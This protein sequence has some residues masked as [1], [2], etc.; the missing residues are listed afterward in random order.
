M[1]IR[2]TKQY[3]T[4][5]LSGKPIALPPLTLIFNRDPSNDDFAQI[6]VSWINSESDTVWVLTSTKNGI[7]NWS[8]SP[9]S[10]LGVFN[11]VTVNPGN[12]DITAGGLTITAGDLNLAAG[13]TFLGG[14]LTVT[15]TT[16]INGDFDLTSAA[17]IDLISTANIDPAIL[18]HSTG[19]V[20]STIRLTVDNGT[21]FDS[22]DLNSVSGGITLDAGLATN[23]AINIAASA[24][25][26]DMT[27]ALKINIDSAEISNS[28]I[29][30]NASA[31]GID[32]TA[33]GAAGLDIDI[34]NTGGSIN[35]ISGEPTSTAIVLNAS[36]VVGGISILSGDFGTAITAAGQVNID[37]SKIAFDAIVLNASLGGIDITAAGGIGLDIDI[38]NTSGSINIISGEAVVDSI[39]L[40]T[41]NIAGGIEIDSGTGGTNIDSTGQIYIVSSQV[42]FD[43]ILLNASAGGIDIT[44]AGA[45]GLDIDIKNTAG[46]VNIISGEAA[47]DSI[48][49]NT[50]NAAGGIYIESGTNGIAIDSTGPTNIDSSEIS[51][52]AIAFNASAGGI[53]ITAAGAPGLDIDIKN[54]AGSINIISNEPIGTAVVLN[55]SSVA[56]GISISSG[57]LGTTI[58]S[59]GALLLNGAANSNFS[60]SGAGVNLALSS[61]AGAV[62]ITSGQNAIDSIVLETDSGILESVRIT[63]KQGTSATSI[64]CQSLVGG[65]SVSTGLATNSS[66]VLNAL[67]GGIDID[68]VL[69]VNI[70]SSEISNNAIA[71]NA[72]A[73]G[74]DITAA[75]AP[76]L[77]IDI[78][79]TSG[80]INIISGEPIDTAVVL[81]ATSVAGGIRINSGGPGTTIGSTGP[82]NFDTTDP[83]NTAIVV[84]AIAGGID[85]I[86]GGVFSVDIKSQGYFTSE[87]GTATDV[88]GPAATAAVTI[89]TNVCL[90]TLS[91][92]TTAAAA[93]LVLTLTNS[94][95]TAGSGIFVSASTLGA[96]DAQMT[97]TR[98][99]PGVGTCDITLT[100]NGAA[101]VNGD[102]LVSVWVFI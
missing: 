94:L 67:T 90:A 21:S 101:A 91:N 83:S 63:S 30:L 64:L 11:S 59:T 82:I 50:S 100:N 48:L 42:A 49:L 25:G 34:N 62:N 99:L 98:V 87:S 2:K 43:A 80:S 16:A 9:A 77:D 72:S 89:N 97:V 26:I 20:L 24:G 1:G 57:S 39:L 58:G 73:G 22:I 17:L 29:L 54:T 7:A 76:G 93:A 15:G 46:S 36:D 31:G 32:I 53:D 13:N 52:S 33:A 96:N 37:S 3:Y 38:R 4:Y 85:L 68:G 44:A 56:G 81:N 8:T 23:L 19:G 41:S 27:G 6:G 51:N 61:A 65:F 92:F 10:G 55:A 40:N 69:Q 14:N 47:I 86:T 18:L 60:V 28:A 71:F 79:N 102:I 78:N 70:A 45:A 95:I 5:S 84:N 74:I 66:I 35:I 75:G 12:I 88:T